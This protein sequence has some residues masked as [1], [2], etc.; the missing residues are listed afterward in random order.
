M[1]PYYVFILP[2]K[3]KNSHKSIFPHFKKSKINCEILQKSNENECIVNVWIL[4]SWHIK[5]N[6]YAIFNSWSS[7]SMCPCVESIPAWHVY[8][9]VGVEQSKWDFLQNINFAKNCFNFK[10]LQNISCLKKTAVQNN[11]LK[12]SFVRKV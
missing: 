10:L 1:C 6:L 4:C 7:N 9:S 8:S 11:N 12:F 5:R 3:I 2:R